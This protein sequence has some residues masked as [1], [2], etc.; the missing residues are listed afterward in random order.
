MKVCKYSI[1]GRVQG[2]GFRYF[3]YGIAA[4]NEIYGYVRNMEDGTVEV[5]AQGEDEK[6]SNFERELFQGPRWSFIQEMKKETI[7]I[8]TPY[9]SFRITY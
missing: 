1:S 8:D 7:E 3:T 2:V 9:E 4:K 5:V 6:I